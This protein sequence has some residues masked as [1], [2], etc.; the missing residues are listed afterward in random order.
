M[1]V[2]KFSF[3][4]ENNFLFHRFL[5]NQHEKVWEK[6]TTFLTLSFSQSK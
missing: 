3:M 1:V 2:K 6:Y 4:M 5:A